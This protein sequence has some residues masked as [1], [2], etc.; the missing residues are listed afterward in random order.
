[1]PFRGVRLLSRK[2]ER[3]DGTDRLH[4]G[5]S[6]ENVT[7]IRGTEIIYDVT[8]VAHRNQTKPLINLVRIAD[9]E[10]LPANPD[11]EAIGA[12]T[13]VFNYADIFF[14]TVPI[15]TSF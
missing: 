13:R 12:S 4:G 1:M 15:L 2:K 5:E 14:C 6:Y 10:I 3:I 8:Y 7:A 11:Y 9:Y